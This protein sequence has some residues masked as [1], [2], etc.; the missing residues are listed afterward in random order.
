MHGF[1][2]CFLLWHLPTS[3]K[4]SKNFVQNHHHYDPSGRS[5]HR[6]GLSKKAQRA[7]LLNFQRSLSSCPLRSVGQFLQRG[8]SIR[9]VRKLRG[10][11]RRLRFCFFSNWSGTRYDLFVRS[12]LFCFF[13]QNHHHSCLFQL[14]K[15][16]ALT[17]LVQQQVL[18]QTSVKHVN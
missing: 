13:E 11:R 8:S 7:H 1:R 15:R 3:I 18:W 16:A 12:R 14:G 2:S 10:L 9:N 5:H 6:F 4:F 17:Q